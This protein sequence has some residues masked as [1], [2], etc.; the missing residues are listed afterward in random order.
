[1]GFKKAFTLI[2]VMVAV[3]IVSVVIAALLK[4]RGDTNHLFSK[5]KQSQNG[6]HY[7]T[8]LLWN[9]N[10]GFENE[11]ANLYRLVSEFDVDDDTRRYLKGV[12]VTL[13][14]EKLETMESDDVTFEVGRSEIKAKDFDISLYRVREP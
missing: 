3:M 1:M 12:E 10:Y 14:Y 2:E 5:M 9:R 11:K 6:S 4:M 8:F 13:S 7:A